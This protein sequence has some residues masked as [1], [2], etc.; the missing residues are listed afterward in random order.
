M[1]MTTPTRAAVPQP[2]ARA[3]ALTP[4]I[5]P[6]PAAPPSRNSTAFNPS[7][8][9]ILVGNYAD[10]SQD[11]ANYHIAGFVPS[12]N[13]GP[14]QRSFNVGESEITLAAPVDPYFNASLTA[15]ISAENTI[16]V[17]EAFFRTT[18]L[19]A[20]LSVKGGRFF[21]GI[22]YLNEIHSHAWD[23][24]DQPLAYQAFL[25]GQYD[26]DGIQV[27]WLAPTDTFLEFGAETGNGQGFPGTRLSRNG[28]NDV[29]L[30]AHVGSDIGES[31]GWRAGLSWLDTQAEDRTYEDLDSLGHPVSNAFTG[32]SRTWIVDATLKWM[33]A[34]DPLR[35]GL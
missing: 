11:P 33:P 29:A 14:G 3:A 24:V 31:I 19:P 34:G 26:Q 1:P 27:K 12:G 30:F 5:S 16:S 15:A 13:E 7:I 9:V 4:V 28:M 8:S 32:T 22:G 35:R 21:S 25:G 6:P 18:A 23:F 17:E 10:L 20:G 2:K